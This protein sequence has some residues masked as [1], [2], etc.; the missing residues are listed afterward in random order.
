MSDD[1]AQLFTAKPSLERS[2]SWSGTTRFSIGSSPNLQQQRSPLTQPVDL[3]GNV[4]EVDMAGSETGMNDSDM[5]LAWGRFKS[6]SL[7]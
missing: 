1:Y 3:N 5:A 6:R 7:G 4:E 2:Y